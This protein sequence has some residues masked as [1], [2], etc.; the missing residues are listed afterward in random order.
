MSLI[1]RKRS[2]LITGGSKGIGLASAT[3]L[4]NQ[5]HNVVILSRTP[6]L[7]SHDNMSWIEVDVSN[8]EK[9]EKH[10][11]VIAKDHNIDAL[12][13]NAGHPSFGNIE[14]WS[15]QQISNHLRTNLVSHMV[16]TSALIPHLRSQKS[17]DVI[18][19]GSIS[20]VKPGKKASVYIAAKAGLK[21]FASALRYEASSKG[22]RVS[23]LQPGMVLTDFYKTQGFAPGPK[24]TE[25]LKP[26][27]VAQ[28]VEHVLSA[29]PWVVFDECT[30]SPLNHV[31]RKS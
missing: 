26:D 27:D 18:L 1:D 16:V 15:A 14:E 13:S 22:V 5:D 28:M 7:V 17:S 23:L 19:M 12:V 29:P 31:V 11:P 9:T 20:A 6:P 2:I 30:F 3:R 10:L 25:H 21:G 4:A 24:D 8:L